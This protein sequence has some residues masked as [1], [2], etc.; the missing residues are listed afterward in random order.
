MGTGSHIIRSKEANTTSGAAGD[1]LRPRPERTN[2]ISDQVQ[3]AQSR[4]PY[5]SRCAKPWSD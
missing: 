1:L 4:G 3:G 2:L 5:P